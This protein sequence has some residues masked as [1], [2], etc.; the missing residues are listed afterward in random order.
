[1][2]LSKFIFIKNF[3][4]DSH[5]IP[6][7]TNYKTAY[8]SNSIIWKITHYLRCNISEDTI[9]KR[10][11]TWFIIWH[12]IFCKHVNLLF[13]HKLLDHIYLIALFAE[14]LSCE[15]RC[16][17]LHFYITLTTCNFMMNQPFVSRWNCVQVGF[18]HHPSF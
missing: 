18:G 4:Q 2:S 3:L 11:I 1:M 16:I 8:I 7:F 10:P 9:S 12:D 17:I 5:L 6:Y 14:C 15:N 13:C